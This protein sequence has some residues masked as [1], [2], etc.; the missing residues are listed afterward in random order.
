MVTV[1]F[2]EDETG[3]LE[4]FQVDGHTGYAK[5]GRDIVCAAV[6]ALAQTAV[7]GLEHYLPARVE[8]RIASGELIC[9]VKGE[10]SEAEA[11]R[12]AT[13]LE[14]LRLGLEA[15]ARD[16]SKYVQLRRVRKDYLEEEK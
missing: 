6:S 4:G 2:F 7:L 11:L 3:R 5:A 13:I 1:D 15:T 14:T 8:S 12:A 9:R 10:L 16:Y